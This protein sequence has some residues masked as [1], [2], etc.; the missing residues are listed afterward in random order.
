MRQRIRVGRLQR[1]QTQLEAMTAVER[2]AWAGNLFGSKA[3]ATACLGADCAVML[4]MMAQASPETRVFVIAPGELT[5]ETLA[6]VEEMKRRLG[7]E[8]QL[9]DLTAP[10]SQTLKQT[11]AALDS[12]EGLADALDDAFCWISDVRHDQAGRNSPRVAL[13]RLDDGLYQ[14]NPLYDWS[15]KKIDAYREQHHLPKPA[16]GGWRIAVNSQAAF[17]ALHGA[18]A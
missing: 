8:V 3:V 10:A 5:E 13:E 9:L 14:L 4:H 16:H 17:S 7:L 6:A 18:R 1:L 15:Q 2:L 11:A 12:G